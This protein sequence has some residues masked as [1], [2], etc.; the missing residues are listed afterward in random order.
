MVRL[1][2][3]VLSLLV[4]QVLG[5]M[6]GIVHADHDSHIHR[7]GAHVQSS[8]LVDIFVGHSEASTCQVF[9]QLSQGSALVSQM[10]ALAL[11]VLTSFFLDIYRGATPLPQ[12][13]L[14]QAR[15]PPAAGL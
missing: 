8:W 7:E 9:D 3:L 5:L 6:H 11:R 13:L 15:G 4:A 1:Y 10:P 2:V 14:I 12:R